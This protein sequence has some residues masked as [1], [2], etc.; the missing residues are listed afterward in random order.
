MD[1]SPKDYYYDL[2]DRRCHVALNDFQKILRHPAKDIPREA[3]CWLLSLEKKKR[4]DSGFDERKKPPE[5]VGQAS[6]ELVLSPGG[7]KTSGRVRE[8]WWAE[9][10]IDQRQLGDR[11]LFVLWTTGASMHCIA[12]HC[13]APAALFDAEENVPQ[14]SRQTDRQQ[15]V[16]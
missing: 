12:L 13:L 6:G 4:R 15:R 14:S 9:G 7:K 5:R 1:H 16:L 11:M 10:Q 2:N 3:M 8:K